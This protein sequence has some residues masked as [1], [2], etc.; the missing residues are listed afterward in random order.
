MW[1]RSNGPSASVLVLILVGVLAPLSWASSD[2]AGHWEGSIAL[3]GQELGIVVDLSQADGQWS[4]TIDIP[5]QG[6]KGL[7]LEGI[8][9]TGEALEFAIAGV[10]G[11][12][13]FKGNLEAAEIKGT[14]TQ[15]TYSFPFRLGREQIPVPARPQE[16]KP[17]FPYRAEEVIYTNGP[18]TL[19]GTL[20]LP[21]GKGPFPAVLLVS[22][23]GAQNRDEEIF[24]HKPFLVL[25]DFLTRAG[26]AV[27]R[28]DDR[29][30]GGS[31]GSLGE[32]TTLDLTQDALAG[33]KYLRQRPEID[34]RRVGILGHSEGGI[35]APLAASQSKEVAFIIMLAGTGMP[36]REILPRQMELLMRAASVSDEKIA[37]VLASQGRL[38]DAIVAGADSSAIRAALRD[39][40]RTQLTAEAGG[41]GPDEK[42][43]ADQAEALLAQMTSPWFRHFLTLDPRPALRRVK[44]PTLVLAGDLDLQVDPDQNLPEIEAALKAAGNKKVTIRRFPGLNHLFQATTSGSSAEY[45]A[46]EETMNPAVLETIRDW[47]LAK[48]QAR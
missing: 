41:Q 42:M 22:G 33:V 16:P 7:A 11:T 1:R 23:S 13:T 39:L 17:P 44:V 8:A 27:L 10:P 29:G 3:P 9:V 12:P 38:L 19:A 2:F 35:I 43:I 25:A 5:M 48:D 45:G 4:G 37:A 46:I 24:G 6:A 26:I 14:F 20:T 18:I 32:S 28:V 30:V 36:G 31:S 34:P 40:L 21:E 15:G 47:L